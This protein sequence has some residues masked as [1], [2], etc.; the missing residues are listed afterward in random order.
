MPHNPEGLLKP[1]RPTL[2]LTRPLAQSQRFAADFRARFGGDWPILCAPLTQLEFHEAL[3]ESQG[4]DDIVFTSQNG[5]VGFSRLTKDRSFRAWC[6]GNR[7]ADAARMAGYDAVTGPGTAKALADRLIADGGVRRILY[8]RADDIAFDMSKY[9][10]AAGIETV[11]ALVYRQR[12]CP[13][14]ADAAALLAGNIPVLLPFFSRRAVE[15]FQKNYTDTRSPI[16]V[17]AISQAVADATDRMAKAACVVARNPDS[18]H[19]HAALA[20]ILS[21]HDKP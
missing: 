13:P 3:I 1:D 6:V 7:T 18:D 16:L 2:L 9:L 14:T 12:P 15:I 19:M 8:P 10:N 21:G 17:A 4:I 20:E 5:V 11:E